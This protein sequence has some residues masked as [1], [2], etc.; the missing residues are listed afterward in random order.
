MGC[1]YGH[2]VKVT[3]YSARVRGYG[4]G[5]ATRRLRVPTLYEETLYCTTDQYAACP[6]FHARQVQINGEEDVCTSET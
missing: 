3:T 6:V 2:P 4:E 5:K 1:P